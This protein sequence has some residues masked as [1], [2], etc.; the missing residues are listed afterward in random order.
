ML[1]TKKQKWQ[2]IYISRLIKKNKNKNQKNEKKGGEVHNIRC[3]SHCYVQ[4]HQSGSVT[5]I[6]IINNKAE[7]DIK[8]NNIY[9]YGFFILHIQTKEG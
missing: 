5:I 4:K 9:I 3:C 8:K 1:K 7:W 2:F 6:I